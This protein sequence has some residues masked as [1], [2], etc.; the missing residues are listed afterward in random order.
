MKKVIGFFRSMKF[1]M[2]LLVLVIACSV[3]GSLIVQQGE[4]M[5]YVRRYGADAAQLIMALGLD[6]VFSAPYFIVLMAALC[7]NLTLCSIVRLPRTIRAAAALRG[8]AHRAIAL[9]PLEEEQAKKLCAFFEKRHYRCEEKDGDRVYTKNMAGFY[10]SFLTHLS[11]LLILIIG[12]AAV[13]TAD[14]RDQVVMPGETLTL[15]DGTMITVERFQIEDETGT[16]DYA[17]VLTAASADGKR[18]KQQ[19]IRVNEPLSF[20][21]YKIYQQTYGTAG[22][23]RIAN[24]TNGIE[25]DMLLTESCFLTLD[26]RNGMFFQAL[27]PGYVQAEDGSVTLV[28]STSGAYEDPVYDILSVSGGVTTPVLAFPDETLTIGDVSFTL[29]DPVSYPGLRIK[30]MHTEILGMLYATFVLIVAALYLC[31]FMV[32]VAVKVTESGYAVLSPK[33]QTGL[34]IELEALLKEEA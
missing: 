6:D 13:M 21:G 33:T 34:M 9:E 32:P 22:A 14:V 17:S 23:V 19:E 12:A 31:F 25:E 29:L 2:I 20:N 3:A 7:L 28:T 4:T 11:F 18:Q 26:G 16:L 5:E 1:G 27:Y 8:Q 10:G 30:H 24:L 15:E